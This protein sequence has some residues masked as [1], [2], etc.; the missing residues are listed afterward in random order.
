MQLTSNLFCEFL[1]EPTLYVDRRKFCQFLA[2]VDFQLEPFNFQICRFSVG[3][4]TGCHILSGGERHRSS[5]E[6]GYSRDQ[7][8]MAIDVGCR[9]TDDQTCNRKNSIICPKDCGPQPSDAT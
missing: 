3:L 8:R 4:T 7:N 6:P 9:H 5:H 1:I 2:A